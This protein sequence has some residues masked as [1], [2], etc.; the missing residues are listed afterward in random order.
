VIWSVIYLVLYPAIPLGVTYTRGL[1]GYDQRAN[2]DSVM[3][4]ARAAQAVFFDRIDAATPEEIRAD[5]EL[6]QFALAGG[7]SAFADNCAPCHGLGGAGNPGGFPVLA[8]DHWLWGGTVE[9]IRYTIVHGVRNDDDPDARLSTMPTY[10]GEFGL[11]TREEI[12]DTAE[13]VLALSGREHDAAAAG[14]GAEIFQQ[15]CVSCHGVDGTGLSEFGAPNLTDAIWLYGGTRE[16]IVAQIA[17]PQ[18]GVMPP[19]GGRLDETTVKMLTVY[20]HGLGGGQ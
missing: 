12:E 18:L 10:G 15:Q 20:V 7:Q 5:P 16:E 4:E 6:L 11:L 2:L 17:S 19:W 14:R 3:A 8:D 9:D 13:Y 1:L